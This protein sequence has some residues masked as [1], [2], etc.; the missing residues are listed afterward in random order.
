MVNKS[1]K[2]RNVNETHMLL[3]VTGSIYSG[4]YHNIELSL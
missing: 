3:L 2:R 4:V 1:M